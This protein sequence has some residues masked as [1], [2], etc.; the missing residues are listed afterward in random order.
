MN[1]PPISRNRQ[2]L[3][4]AAL[5]WL[6][7][8][9]DPNLADLLQEYEPDEVLAA[10]RTG[11][12]PASYCDDNPAR[13][14]LR[15]WQLRLPA[16]PDDNTIAAACRNGI[17]I[18]CPGDLEWPAGLEDLGPS[19]PYAL[20]LRGSGDLQEVS[21]RSITV[22]GSRA[23]SGYGVHVASG[24]AADLAERDWLIV[25]GGA[26]GI[27]AAAHRGALIN[28]G[29]T[30]SVLASGVDRP[31]PAGHDS[32]FADIADG[33]LLI[34]EW[35]PGTH[36]SR[37]RFALRNY[38]MAALTQAMMIV[39]AGQYSGALNAARQ[40][41]ELGRPVMAVPGPVTSAQSQGCH[42]LIRE[43]NATLITCADD[44]ITTVGR[45]TPVTVNG[46]RVIASRTCQARDGELA[47]QRYVVCIDKSGEPGRQHI[48]WTIAFD[49]GYQGGQW[50]AGNGRYD[51]SH[52]RALA[53]MHERA[54]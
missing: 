6:A 36:P 19:R 20:W 32:L 28:G 7:E 34:S 41:A 21:A 22:T 48:V 31:Y 23:A 8:P 50:V 43:S 12:L 4:R 24:M 11:A 44:V 38:T 46:L 42:L 10:I 15:R 49:P 51:L 54:S 40:A 13:R 35:P 53:V 47:D 3:A 25:S 5:T 33:G 14:A 17:R 39:E 26:Y 18:A 52:E 45:R 1:T 9:R 30:I 2:R 27:D 29:T 37:N 16:L